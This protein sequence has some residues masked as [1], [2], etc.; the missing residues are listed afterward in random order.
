VT[1]Y[2]DLLDE[3][4]LVRRPVEAVPINADVYQIVQENANE[5]DE[6]WGFSTGAKVR[7]RYV[8]AGDRKDTLLV[9]Y[10]EIPG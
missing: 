3:G 2:V 10:E 9:A 5:E 1:I 4:T 7:C 6:N 8:V